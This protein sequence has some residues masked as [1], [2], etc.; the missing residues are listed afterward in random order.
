MRLK[1]CLF[2]LLIGLMVAPVLA[3]D[4]TPRLEATDCWM[5]MPDGVEEGKDAECGYLVVPEDRSNA[6]SPT[7][8]L[9]YVVLHASSDAVKPDPVIYLSGGPGGNAVA[10]LEGWVGTPYV[11]DRDLVLLDQRGTGYSLPTLNCPEAEQGEENAVQAC[12]D[13]L[14]SEGVNLQAY[15]S[16]ENAADVADLRAA[17]GYKEWNLF[18][19]S[20][21]TRLALTVMRDH[22]EGVRSVVIDSVYPPEVNSW[23]EYGANTADV[24]HRVFQ[25]CTDNADC[26]AA[27]PDLEKTFY[28]TVN[29]LNANPASYTGTDS[30]TGESTDKTLSGNDLIERVFQILYVSSSIPG[31]PMAISEVANGNYVALDDLEAGNASEGALRQSADEDVSDSEGMNNSVDCQEEVAF[32]DEAKA[33]ANVPAD[34]PQLHDNSVDSIKS[35]FSDCQIWGVKAADPKEAKPVV[36]DIP[37]LV[38]AGEFDPI[39]PAKWAKSAAS[40]LLNSTFFL[41]PGGGHGVVDLNECTQGIMQA[42]LDDPTQK[43]DGSCVASIGEPAW[44]LPS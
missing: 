17:L 11:Q 26:N 33:I 6:A 43:P 13:R 25:A 22:P 30:T 42:F 2:A 24:F 38:T 3:Q 35:T 44:V 21:G 10:E 36:S 20:Y 32:N 19:I 1:Y 18:G 15:N 8:Q 41:F 34:P 28:D 5:A 37:T 31:L 29:Q 23:E 40:Y 14:V 27:Y 4:T 12:H 39:T 9:A 7:I 16:A